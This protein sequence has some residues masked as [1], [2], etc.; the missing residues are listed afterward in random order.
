MKPAGPLKHFAL[1]F[2][3]AV[4]IYTIFYTGIEH[5]RT[6]RG[7]WRVVFTNTAAGVPR[8]VVSQPKLG[9]TNLMLD[10]PN[11]KLPLIVSNSL[12]VCDTPREVPF[13]VPFG[14]CI[15]MDTTFLPGTVTFNLFSHEIE[16]L[17][18]VLIINRKE[19]SWKSETN[20]SVSGVGVM[21]I[22]PKN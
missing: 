3:I 2:L 21:S 5:R 17:P 22:Q 13:P 1:A 9:I 8:L 19:Y 18:R 7:P 11:E 16:L 12:M 14:Q 4:V 15:F 10:F 20:I 6:F